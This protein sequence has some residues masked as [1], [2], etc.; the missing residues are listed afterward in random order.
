[1]LCLPGEEAG[2]DLALRALVLPAVHRAVER[3]PQDLPRVQGD[4]A[5]HGRRMGEIRRC[6]VGQN[7]TLLFQVISD[8]PDSIDI[9]TE[10]QKSLMEIASTP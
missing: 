2:R 1:M 10:I 9:A 7:M 5:V 8:G 3:Q 6:N 4:R